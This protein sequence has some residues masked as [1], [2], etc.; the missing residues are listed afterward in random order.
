M[1]ICIVELV[2]CIVCICDNFYLEIRSY[3]KRKYWVKF[4]AIIFNDV[5]INLHRS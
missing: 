2:T 1:Q 5:Y 4:D 3:F